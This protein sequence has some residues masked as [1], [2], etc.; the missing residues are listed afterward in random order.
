MIGAQS[1]RDGGDAFA[2]HSCLGS[3]QMSFQRGAVLEGDVHLLAQQ[4]VCV[5]MGS[6]GV[7]L[8]QGVAPQAE[9]HRHGQLVDEE[10]V[11]K[12]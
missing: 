12:C 2:P 11:H 5:E 6:R 1:M 8:A 7:Q 9:R 10:S 3:N 4:P